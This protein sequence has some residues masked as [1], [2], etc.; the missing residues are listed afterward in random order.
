MFDVLII[1][2][3]IVGCSIGRQLSRYAIRV[4]LLE[5]N[6]EVGQETTKANS[7]IVHGGFDCVPGTK[8]AAMNVRGNQMMAKLSEELGFTYH[9][10]GSLVLAFDEEEIAQLQ[11]LLER[12]Q[13]NGV[14]PLSLL[15]P[16]EILALEPRVSPNVKKALYCPNSGVVDP[17]NFTY[18]MIENAIE[19]GLSLFTETEVI[20]ME[21]HDDHLLVKT[22]V[23]DKKARFVVNAAGL[24]SARIAA[25]TGDTEIRL[26]P[27][28]GVYRLLDKTD[29]ERIHTVLFQTPTRKG[30]G[31]LVAP[32][33]DGSTLVGPTA[34]VV[35]DEHD[36]TVNEEDLRAVDALACKSVPNLAL[37]QT[38]RVFTG[39]RAKPES[40]DFHLYASKH[41][42][43]VIHAAGIESPGLVS[44]PAIAE[45]VDRLLHAN[46]FAAPQ[47]TDFQPRR[48]AFVRMAELTAA[49][50]AE[51][52]AQNPLYG[53]II[54]RCET[55]SE[56]EIVDAIH[57]PG[58]A[59][60]LDGV[61]RRVRAGMG[62]C[63]GG[64]CAPRVMAI[65]AR[66]RNVDPVTLKK[67]SSESPLLVGHLKYKNT[68]S[69][70]H[71]P[72]DAAKYDSKRQCV[73]MENR[74]QQETE[75]D[76]L[77]EDH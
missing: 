73:E 35:D 24:G 5:K 62:R 58:G 74:E 1:G 77:H 49:E 34:S 9:Q 7:A 39:V 25:M 31:V 48:K 53:N 68:L 28:K 45:E 72:D 26:R 20:G 12:G 37:G 57:R 4:G 70:P 17:F 54:C 8:K 33:Y 66:E 50:K 40:G 59:C 75:Q 47:K 43:G 56:G 69:N 6:I 16:P 13:K 52:I 27:T 19:N 18:G 46:G 67:E 29:G 30:K 65:L 11:I 10:V 21:R 38:I 61:K 32:T 23:G 14:S 44:A 55:V 63:Q 3:G 64:F 41:M 36:T 60:T 22:N 15:D 71:H 2:G 51:Q 42:P 76:L